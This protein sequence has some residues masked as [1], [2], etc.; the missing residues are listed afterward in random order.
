MCYYL[1]VDVVIFGVLVV[2]CYVLFDVGVD[3]IVE[4]D[5]VF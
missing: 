2:F 1:E 3:C 5:E 4:I